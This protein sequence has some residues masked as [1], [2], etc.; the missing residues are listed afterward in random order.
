MLLTIN[1]PPGNRSF[2]RPA[3]SWTRTQSGCHLTTAPRIDQPLAEHLGRVRLLQGTNSLRQWDKWLD[4]VASVS[5]GFITACPD[6]NS[7]TQEVFENSIP[8]SEC[9]C[10]AFM[11]STSSWSTLSTNLVSRPAA[12]LLSV[13]SA[14]MSLPLPAIVCGWP[15]GPGIN[16]CTTTVF[17]CPYEYEQDTAS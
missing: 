14:Q 16:H 11:D 8:L 15:V 10:S 3:L 13:C 7:G 5:L 6:R 12:P 1:A 17:G 4:A 2:R 9:V